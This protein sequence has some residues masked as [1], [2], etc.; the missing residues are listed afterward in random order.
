MYHQ[1]TQ[2]V[3]KI[4]QKNVES[5]ESAE[6]KQKILLDID[7]LE[8]VPDVL[9]IEE[10]GKNIREENLVLQGYKLMTFS[11]KTRGSAIYVRNGIGFGKFIKLPD[12]KTT[13]MDSTWIFAEISEVEYIIG[14]IYRNEMDNVEDFNFEMSALMFKLEEKYPNA[15]I[16]IG[17]DFNL[18]NVGTSVFNEK[19]DKG[20]SEFLSTMASFGYTLINNQ[21]DPTFVY[22]DGDKFSCLDLVFSNTP[23]L[24]RAKVIQ[25]CLWKKK[26]HSGIYY[27]I[28]LMNGVRGKKELRKSPAP[29]RPK[30]EKD[31][32]KVLEERFEEL[33]WELIKTYQKIAVDPKSINR[34]NI[35][36]GRANFEIRMGEI[37]G[38]K[39]KEMEQRMEELGKRYKKIIREGQREK[40]KKQGGRRKK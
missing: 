20:S 35:E 37:V 5:M 34:K 12:M 25:E 18:R 40:W 4:Y 36:Y 22:G 31:E 9:C 26:T 10:L 11:A 27:E 32:V 30:G 24:T 17:G 6:A 28:V 16:C 13:V 21:Q 1:E 3:L 33:L 7:N 14:N 29:W 2:K 19:N 39:G 38:Q 15:I 8:K 23:T